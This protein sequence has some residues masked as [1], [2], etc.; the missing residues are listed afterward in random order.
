DMF[1]PQ[2]RNEAFAAERQIEPPDKGGVAVKPEPEAV[3]HVEIA[4]FEILPMKGH[5]AGVHEYSTVERPPCFP[6]VLGA[7]GHTVAILETELAESAERPRAA[8]RRLKVERHFLSRVRIG[9]DRRRMERNRPI[10]V[11]NWHVLLQIDRDFAKAERVEIPIV[12]VG[13]LH[14]VAA[15][16]VRMRRIVAPVERGGTLAAN[17][18]GLPLVTGN[19]RGIEDLIRRG[20]AAVVAASDRRVEVSDAARDV[21]QPRCPFQLRP[22]FRASQ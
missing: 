6:A 1:E 3:R 4:Q 10:A 7:Q 17:V 15:A 22:C 8:E 14:A 18:S 9:K 21:K 5:L 2:E 11:W 13:E 19:R 20:K 16:R 12:V